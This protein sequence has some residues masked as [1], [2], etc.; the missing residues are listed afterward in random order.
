M[1]QTTATPGT[2][3]SLTP[4]TIY[5]EYVY[6]RM[7]DDRHVTLQ[8]WGFMVVCHPLPVGNYDAETDGGKVLILH[9]FWPDPRNPNS[10]GK[11]GKLKYRIVGAW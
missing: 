8:C 9:V 2:P 7:P 6:A 1:C 10:P 5:N 4:I 3:P 11:P